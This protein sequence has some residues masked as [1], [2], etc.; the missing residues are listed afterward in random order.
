[1]AGI[2]HINDGK[3][4]QNT[5]AQSSA[6][7]ANSHANDATPQSAAGEAIAGASTNV[8]DTGES[9]TKAK[10]TL[11]DFKD[12]KANAVDV[13]MAVK[14]AFDSVKGLTGKISESLMMPVMKALGPFKGQAI[15]PAVKQM[16]PVMGVDVHMVTIPPSPAPVPMPHPYI[17][18]LFNPKDFVSC[19]I[20]TF[21]KDL[22]DTLPPPAEDDKSMMA[23]VAKNKEAI[24][25]I[26]M[27][28]A[29]LSASVKFGDF[30][31]RAVT[32]TPTKNIPHI[33]MGAGFHPAFA[34]S[35][36]KNH[37]KA[38]LGSLFVAADGD[39]MC[40]SFHLHYDCWDIGVVDLFKGQRAGA[41]KS[42]PP[43]SAQAQ[44]Y[45]PSGVMTPIPIGRPVLVN[46]IPT[47]IN[48]LSIADKLFKAGLGKLAKAARKVAQAGLNKLNG[49]VGCGPLTAASKLIG[50]GQSHPVDVSSGHFYTDNIDFK[51]PGPIPLFWERTW[52]SYSTYNG[53][54]GYGW[55]HSYDL[56]LAID[57]V[58]EAA[59]MRLADGRVAHF[60]LPQ[61]NKESYNRGEKLTLHLHEEGYYYAVDKAGLIY[62]FT[63]KIYRNAINKTETHLLK[64]V[65]NRNG[66]AI[67][68][69]YD[70]SAVLK[71]IIDS[72]GRKL[73][74]NSDSQGRIINIEA[75][76][77][78]YQGR[79][80]FPITAYT[81]SPEGDMSSQA[82]ALNQAMYFEYANHLMVKEVWRNGCVWTL[83]YNKAE[84][85]DA[86]CIEVKGTGGLLHYKFDYTDPKCTVV[87]NSRG[88]KKQF[89]HKNGVV[90]KYID[91]L[92]AEWNYHFNAFNELEWET[93][94]LGNQ[95]TTTYD[96]WGNVE[97]I[98]EPNGAFTQIMYGSGFLKHIPVESIDKGGGKWKWDYDGFG[99]LVKR[100]NPI[101]AETRFE[102]EDGFLKTIINAK[103]S[104]TLLEYDRA[105][106]LSMVVASNGYEMQW[107]YDVLGNCT[108]SVDSVGNTRKVEFNIGSLPITI[109]EP[110]GNTRYLKFDAEANVIE[111]KDKHYNI[112]F[113]YDALNHIIAR[114][115]AGQTVNYKYDTES[116]L[117]QLTNEHN[118]N[119]IFEID[120]ADRVVKEIGFDGLVRNYSR[121][122]AGKVIKVDRPGNK[123]T[124]YNYDAVGN[125]TD[126]NYHDDSFEK[127]TYLKNG[128][129]NTAANSNAVI[130]F[131][132]DILGRIIKETNAE[133]FISYQYDLLGNRTQITSSLGANINNEFDDLNNV[134]HTNA[135]GWQ[136]NMNYNELG[137]EIERL[138]PGNISS[139]LTRDK[140]GRTIV[141]NI[142]NTQTTLHNRQYTWDVNYRLQRITDS[143]TG[144]TQF[145]HDE[146][147]NLTK[148]IFS[149]GTEQLRNPDPVGNLFNTPDRKDRDYGR[150]GKL[151]KAN[152]TTFK[153]D[154]EGNLIEKREAVG[155][156]WLYQWNASGML[157]S[158]KRPD[159]ETVSFLYDA[160]GRRISKKF[161]NTNTKW[162]WDGNKPLHEWKE[163]ASTGAILSNTTVNED[164][165][166]TWLFNEYSFAPAAKLKGD[167]KYSIITDHLGTPYQMYKENGEILWETQLDS[168]G[169]VRMFKGEE[170]SCPFRYQGQYEDI[171]TG[172]YYNRFRYYDATEGNFISQDPIGLLGGI[173]LY[174]YVFDPNTWLDELGLKSN[175]EMLGDN[176]GEPPGENHDAH[177]IVMSGSQDHADLRERMADHGIDINNKENGIWLP[178]SEDDRVDNRTAHKGEG[179]HSDA[180]KKEVH[181]RL[182]RTRSKKAFLKELAKIKRELL[183]GKKY[184]CKK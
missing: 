142:R 162:L 57:T 153:Y 26:A 155:K 18:I 181:D 108:R 90:I 76:D 72:A 178:R 89:Y 180:Y 144:I 14:G 82:D 159:G 117:V 115:Q 182:M 84:G 15:L 131:E 66:F 129:L 125:I 169:K 12:G 167:K 148:T 24:A 81:Y 45:V 22:L 91:P 58:S 36:A 106:N 172:L 35:V 17:G 150:G 134:T 10:D 63:E 32:G 53:P 44:L 145:S 126:V 124:Q 96:K 100:T 99:N 105:F 83:K 123:F 33:P 164:G 55:H 95:K 116:N 152:G 121:D 101:N 136:S 5:P 138:L 1:M 9:L 20:N 118:E 168:Y 31:P 62:R 127:Y 7:G 154:D 133:D 103:G 176:L 42:P 41:K 25:G 40:G 175:S 69:S 30:I 6:T 38:F 98:I 4:H 112:R 23:S 61:L 65:A 179:V 78:R 110:D 174:N 79:S 113:A 104:K 107:S 151:L 157:Q 170:G 8:H 122:T 11:R 143:S 184:P 130:G 114:S 60:E 93:D 67:R 161:K 68:F 29:G 109:N 173:K 28:L 51:L 21:K 70:D 97:S 160:L 13:A 47:P 56:A 102:Y 94:P 137:L 3:D 158:V 87:I 64:S 85:P 48:P 141:Q 163:N 43:G 92:N 77:P 88:F 156:A 50:T 147:G 166:I 146:I 149:D 165:I 139:K 119:Y 27:G 52:H 75:P 19:A 132:R 111:A 59:I 183:N 74:V 171:E 128:L 120:A 80:S 37:G 135:N 140:L 16:D 46:S 177:H 71:E 39:P 34:A 73:Q 49:K 86:K 2:E 54:M